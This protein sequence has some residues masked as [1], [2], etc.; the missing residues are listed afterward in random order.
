MKT[1]KEKYELLKEIDKEDS[2]EMFIG[3]GLSFLFVLAAFELM[4][5][6]IAFFGA[7]KVECNLL[8]CTFTTER[9]TVDERTIV[10]SSQECYQNGVKINCSEI[11]EM[12]KMTY[13]GNGMWGYE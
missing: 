4:L 7:D 1:N 3:I 6:G 2:K 10:S 13:Y 12:P 11:K 8:W 9:T 5:L